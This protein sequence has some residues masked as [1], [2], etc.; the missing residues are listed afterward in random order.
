[1]KDQDLASKCKKRWEER[2]KGKVFGT[3]DLHHEQRDVALKE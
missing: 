3:E 1:M 2:E